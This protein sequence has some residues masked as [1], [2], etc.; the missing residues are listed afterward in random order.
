MSDLPMLIR[1]LG[2][3]NEKRLKDAI[4][5]ML[6]DQVQKD[7]ETA[8]EYIIYYDELFD[9]IRCEVEKRVKEKVVVDYTGKLVAKVTDMLDKSFK[10]GESNEDC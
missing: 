9:E 2:E 10:K 1:L 4:T 7:L 3:E 8:D 5:D 6:I